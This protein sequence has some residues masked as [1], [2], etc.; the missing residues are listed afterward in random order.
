M[1]A[2]VAGWNCN[3]AAFSMRCTQMVSRLLIFMSR[4]QAFLCYNRNQLY[5][6]IEDKCFHP[7]TK[8]RFMYWY[9][10][11]CSSSQSNSSVGRF[12]IHSNMLFCKLG[13]PMMNT[14]IILI[15]RFIIYFFFAFLVKVNNCIHRAVVRS[16]C[17]VWRGFKLLLRA[18][19]RVFAQKR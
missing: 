11:F 15:L 14:L 19:L 6:V 8:I 18:A 7:C 5:F 16:V 1:Y 17:E 12:F 13:L 4:K 10:C 3:S 2:E 9:Y